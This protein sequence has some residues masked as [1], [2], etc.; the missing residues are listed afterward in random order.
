MK[1]FVFVICFSMLIALFLNEAVAQTP[2]EQVRV[3]PLSSPEEEQIRIRARKRL[4]PGGKDQEN[5]K[6][7]AQLQAPTRRMTPATEA[8]TETTT[9]V[10]ASE[11]HD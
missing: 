9:E 2:P 5:L 7:Q 10:P 4:Y 11:E 3:N 6:V 1:K 8:P